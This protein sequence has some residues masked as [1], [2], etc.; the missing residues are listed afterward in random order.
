MKASMWAMSSLRLVKDAPLSDCVDRIE[1]QISIWLRPGGVGRRVVEIN[2]LVALEPDV[3][4]GLAD[5]EIVE[6]DVDFALRMGGDDPV[7]EI[8]ELDASASFIVA[9]ADCAADD[10]QRLKTAWLSHGAG[11]MR[12]AG[13]RPPVG[14]L[15]VALRAFERLDGRLF[16]DGEHDGVVRRGQV[17]PDDVGRLGGEFGTAADAPG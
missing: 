10:I 17:E 4:L 7:H 13:H 9:A 8:E 16:V 6:D 5:G 12:L 1:N 3:A 2:V 14:R 15:E 11:S